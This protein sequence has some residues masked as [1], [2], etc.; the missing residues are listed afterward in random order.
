MPTQQCNSSKLSPRVYELP[1]F[2]KSLLLKAVGY[3]HN[4]HTITTPKGTRCLEGQY[5]S[6]QSSLLGKTIDDFS[7]PAAYIDDFSS[8]AAYIVPSCTMNAGHQGGHP[9]ISSRQT[10][11][12]LQPTCVVSSAMKSC[13]L[14]LMGS[15]EYRQFSMVLGDLWDLDQQFMEKYPPHVSGRFI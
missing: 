5:Y 6:M 15:Q 14:V 3:L 10:S 9:H 1:S 7:T 13:H 2:M 12:D 4:P 11:L 8:P